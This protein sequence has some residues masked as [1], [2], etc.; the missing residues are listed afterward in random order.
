MQLALVAIAGVEAD[1]AVVGH[2]TVYE[3]EI[4]IV[5]RRIDLHAFGQAVEDEAENG[6]RVVD[7][8]RS[9]S[10]DLLDIALIGLELWPVLR[11]RDRRACRRHCGQK[12]SDPA[13]RSRAPSPSRPA[14][15]LASRITHAGAP[16]RPGSA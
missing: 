4:E 7:R 6:H 16:S 3:G 10:T 15:V 11:L 2:A 12:R 9:R 5:L 14:A 8:K 13:D 1:I